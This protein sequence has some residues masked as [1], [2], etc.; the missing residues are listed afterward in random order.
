MIA[1][2]VELKNFSFYTQKDGLSNYNIHKIIQ[3]DKKFLW[4]ATQDGLNRFDGHTFVV[5]NKGLE[6]KRALLSNDIRDLIYDSVQNIL[7]VVCNEGGINGID[8][9][10]GTV[11][12]AIVYNNKALE[13]HW[14][15]CACAYGNYIFIGTS[16]GLELFDTRTQTFRQ[17]SL[18]TSLFSV[19]NASFNIRA[20][21]LDEHNNIW[22]D[23]LNK[24][25][26]IYHPLQHKILGQL[27]QTQIQKNNTYTF[28]RFAAPSHR[29][30]ITGWEQ[31]KECI[32]YIMIP[33]ITFP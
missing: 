14:R 27:S 15:I 29:Q 5:Y 26:F 25:I 17:Q 6:P 22:I 32:R 31:K 11:K 23:A 3:D 19:A 10:T 16:G 9:I 7:W 33:T 28:W 21:N 2:S 13:R 18:L 8:I 4:I 30:E 1:Q 20:L 12:H 24:G